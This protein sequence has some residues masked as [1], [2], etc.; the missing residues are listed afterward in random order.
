[1]GALADSALVQ[2]VIIALG[3]FAFVKFCSFAKKFSLP[4]KVKLSTYIL[5]GLGLLIMNYMFSA[6]K[7]GQGAATVMSNPALM[8]ISL[9]VS[10][11]IVFIFSFALMAETKE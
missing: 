2:L 5:T 7:T 6:A 1:M 3:I 9:A 8:Y 11:L 10:L 4:G